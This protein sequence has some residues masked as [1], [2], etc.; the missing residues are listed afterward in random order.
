MLRVGERV[1]DFVTLAGC[2]SAGSVA[3]QPVSKQA[4]LAQGGTYRGNICLIWCFWGY[5]DDDYRWLVAIVKPSMKSNRRR[6]YS[7]GAFP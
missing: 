6:R 4:D 2:R 1:C 3:S 7:G 5:V